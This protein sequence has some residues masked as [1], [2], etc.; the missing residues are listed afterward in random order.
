M[1]F[2]PHGFSLPNVVNQ[3]RNYVNTLNGESVG[4][5]LNANAEPC[6]CQGERVHEADGFN[7]VKKGDVEK[8]WTKV[9]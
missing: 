2:Y 4:F 9:V 8:D 6:M 3:L 7:N 1:C 5:Q